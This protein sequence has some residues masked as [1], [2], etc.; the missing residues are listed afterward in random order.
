MKHARPARCAGDTPLHHA[1][2]GDNPELVR[3]LLGA[4]A[5]ATPTP[6]T[7][8]TTPTW[9][10][11]S[12]RVLT[13]TPTHSTPP[14]HPPTHTHR[15]LTLHPDPHPDHHPDPGAIAT[16]A[17]ASGRLPHDLATD[18][19]VHAM[20]Q[21]SHGHGV[22]AR[23]HASM[24][25]SAAMGG[26]RHAEGG[27]TGGMRTGGTTMGTM[28]SLDESEESGDEADDKEMEPVR[29]APRGGPP[30]RP[31]PVSNSLEDPEQWPEPEDENHAVHVAPPK[32][33]A[34][35]SLPAMLY[36][37]PSSSV[38]MLSASQLVADLQRLL[39]SQEIE[40]KRLLTLPKGV[41]ADEV[42]CDVMRSSVSPMVYRCFLRLG[43]LSS[44]RICIFE[45]Q[46]RADSAVFGGAAAHCPGLLGLARPG[47]GLRYAL[48][49]RRRAAQGPMG[50]WDGRLRCGQSRRLCG[51]HHPGGAL[52]QG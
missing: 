34:Q 25:P 8:T 35:P 6:T 45:A 18:K 16:V 46:R 41:G 37:E 38:Q 28:A 49:T 47:S 31:R 14:Q 42:Q 17:D 22:E 39:H 2:R 3:L 36:G 20:L 23:E 52:A 24:P 40:P 11:G 29:P 4:G 12:Q 15:H 32:D 33:T 1:A 10:L 13:R 5:L 27:T 43:G 26:G 51:V 21:P 7:P 19:A 9:I 30:Q 50:G 48:G 44:R